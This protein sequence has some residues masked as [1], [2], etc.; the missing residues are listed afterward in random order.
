[1]AIFVQIN[2]E[3]HTLE[4][5]LSVYD[6]LILLDMPLDKIAVECN[7]EIVPRSLFNETRIGDGDQLEIIHF[8]GGG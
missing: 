3:Q 4:A 5:E 1:M 8:I 7:R 6:V 2:G